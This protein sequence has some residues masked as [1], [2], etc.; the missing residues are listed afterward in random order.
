VIERLVYY[1]QRGG[2]LQTAVFSDINEVGDRRFAT[3]I[4]IEDRFGDR[5]LQRIELAEF[6]IELDAGL[7]SLDTFETWGEKR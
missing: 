1:D 5:T 6:D 3:T 2:V 7:F 4:L